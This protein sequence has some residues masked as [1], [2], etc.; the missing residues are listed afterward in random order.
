MSRAVSS[1]ARSAQPNVRQCGNGSGA[2]AGRVR[3]RCRAHAQIFTLVASQPGVPPALP[4]TPAA[5]RPGAE[6]TPAGPVACRPRRD[7]L[8]LLAH[9]A[10]AAY[11]WVGGVFE[12]DGA[13]TP[14]LTGLQLQHDDPGWL[15]R[16][17]AFYAR[18]EDPSAFL[19]PALALVAEPDGRSG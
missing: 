4:P 9:H 1:P 18:D 6:A 2:L 7:A 16:L 8:D 12:G 13:E 11:L 17:P 5:P 15:R 14:T 19:Q 10:P 3:S